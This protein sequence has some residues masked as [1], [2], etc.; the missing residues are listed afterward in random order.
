M[1]CWGT[2]NVHDYFDYATGLDIDSFFEWSARN[3]SITY[4]HNLAY[5]GSF[6]IDA[7]LR[8]GYL[9]VRDRAQEKG[10]FTT[11]I[12]G[13]GKFYSITVNI[14]GSIT[15]YRDSMK[16][17][18]MSVADIARAFDTPE[19]K[20][21]IDYAAPRPVGY[22]PSDAEWDYL[23][24]DV[25]IV[26]MAM[27][28]MM[29][30]GMT[31]MTA[32]S[33]SMS[34]YKKSIGGSRAFSKMFPN[35]SRDIDDSVREAYRGGFTYANVLTAGQLVGEGSVYDVNSLYP[36]VMATRL[37]PYGSPET[38]QGEPPASGLWVASAS[39]MA[40][41][42]PDHVPC[43][44]VKKNPLFRGTEY[45]EVI[46]VP[47]TVSMSS[48]D[49]AL[50][51]DH[52]DLEVVEWHGGLVF[53]SADDM[54][55]PYVEKWMAVKEVSVGG[56]R[57]IAKLFLNS[58]YGKFAKNTDVTSKVPVLEDGQVRL[59]KGP[60]EECNPVYTALGVFVTAWARDYTV[61]A[62]QMNFDRFLYADTDSL[63]LLGTEPPEGCDVHPTHLGAWKHEADF[64]EGVY[65]RAKQYSEMIGGES[66]THIAGLPRRIAVGVS[67]SD[68][69]APQEWR[70]K[71]VPQRVRGGVVLKETTFSFT[72]IGANNG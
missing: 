3:P 54:I 22:E 26:S 51:C 25:L 31:A 13:L 52:Y 24:R 42:K 12:D 47:T 20:G 55:R 10:T 21:V 60:H 50:W 45:Q 5:D 8:K 37:L 15:E 1:W 32:S 7:L 49:F 19:S 35:V 28:E 64:S 57:T 6:I 62:A 17:L 63:H 23:R 18:P 61:R 30:Q 2:M 41:L 53:S 36:Y 38:F 59:K 11:L 14:D 56:K 66:D 58:L 46:D 33:D 71:L 65:V 16:K 72:P 34:E 69:L 29:S 70:G 44:Q 9:H 27:R 4:F 39:I 68:L 43:I 48:V 67:P 40:T